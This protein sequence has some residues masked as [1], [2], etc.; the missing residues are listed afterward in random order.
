MAD[1][2]TQTPDSQEWCTIAYTAERLA[3]SLRTVT[4]MI[5]DGRLRATKPRIGSRESARH[6]TLIALSDV[7]EYAR[8]LAIVRAQADGNEGVERA[9]V[10]HG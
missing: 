9:L 4:R 3:V 2:K 5:A 1:M 7:N 6:K 8:A 10:R